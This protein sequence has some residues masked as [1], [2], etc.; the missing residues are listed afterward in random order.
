MPKREKETELPAGAGKYTKY[1][2][3]SYLPDN[4]VRRIDEI[5]DSYYK[6]GMKPNLMAIKGDSAPRFPSKVSSISS[7][8]LGDIYGEFSAW[9]SFTSDK[10]KY[11]LVACNHIESEM[12]MAIDMEV[13]NMVSDK[14]NIEAKKAKARSSE[15]YMMLTSYHQKLMGLK[16]MLSTE[17][18]SY[19]Q[20]ITSLSREMSRREVNAGF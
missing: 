17:L 19:L 14:G 15:K 5:F 20:S 1:I 7:P 13:G 12:A 10:F 9:H 18:S 8:D 16:I 11:V 3:L 4:I 6:M 2:D